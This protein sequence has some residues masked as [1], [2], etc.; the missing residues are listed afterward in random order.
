MNFKKKSEFQNEAYNSQHATFKYCLIHAII[1]IRDL[2]RK[3]NILFACTSYIIW[4]LK[5]KKYI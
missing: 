2:L 5:K 1:Q 4:Y 3:I